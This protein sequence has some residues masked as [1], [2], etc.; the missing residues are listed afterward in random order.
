MPPSTTRYENAWKASQA[1]PDPDRFTVETPPDSA[2]GDR[3]EMPNAVIMIDAPMAYGGGEIVSHD[4][5]WENFSRL[6]P[7]DHIDNTPVYGPGNASDK[8]HGY[9]GISA[10]LSANEPSS[11]DPIATPGYGRSFLGLMRARDMGAARRATRQN[12]KYK[13]WN[14]TWF[15]N[16]IDGFR[17]IPLS[18]NSGEAVLRRGINGYPEND[19]EGGRSRGNNSHSWRVESPSWKLGTYLQTNIQ[20]DFTPPNRTHGEVKMVHPHIV[21]IIGDAPPP[22]KSDKY[23]SP[24]SSLQKFLPKRRSNTGLRRVPGPWDE[25]IIATYPDVTGLPGADGMVVP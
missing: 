12:P 25:D 13:F 22:D 1:Y 24:F 3:S 10:P 20:R 17:T 19:G 21:T 15:A 6:N 16:V 14:E 8:G 9:G 23:A 5:I 11:K 18:A 2:H 4:V 7:S